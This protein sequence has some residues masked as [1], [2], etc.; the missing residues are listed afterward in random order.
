MLN[1]PVSDQDFQ[2]HATDVANEVVISVAV[3]H[4]VINPTNLAALTP[5]TTTYQN[6][7]FNAPRKEDFGSYIL[8]NSQDSVPGVTRFFFGK[9]KDTAAKNTAVRTWYNW[10]DYHW[11]NVLEM[12]KFYVPKTGSWGFSSYGPYTTP[13]WTSNRFD[14]SGETTRE[15]HTPLVVVKRVRESHSGLTKM[16]Y[17]LFQSPT[18]WTSAELDDHLQHTEDALLAG[19]HA[20]GKPQPNSVWWDLPGSRD[21]VPDCLHGSIYIPASYAEDYST[22]TTPLYEQVSGG[23]TSAG[24]SVPARNYASTQD[25]D[26]NTCTTW[27]SHTAGNEVKWTG[28]VYQRLRVTAIKPP[29][30]TIET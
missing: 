2:I 13:Y 4:S 9:N 7:P 16:R 15:D 29:M 17:D 28:A 8:S 25:S 21:S 5:G 24:S 26:G 19:V 11:P 22:D 14:E 30:P 6:F 1:Q 10:E 27:A 23:T 12:L 3:A 18:P 20:V